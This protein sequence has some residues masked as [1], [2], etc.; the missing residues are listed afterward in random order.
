MSTKIKSNS[1]IC[2]QCQHSFVWVKS[3]NKLCWWCEK[4]LLPEEL[5]QT[6][7]SL[8]TTSKVTAIRWL[9]EG[10]RFRIVGTDKEGVLI[11]TNECR[12]LTHIAGN[13]E[14]VA[15]GTEVV[16][17]P[18][19]VKIDQ[20]HNSIAKDEKKLLTK[21]AVVNPTGKCLCGCGEPTSGSKFKPGHDARFHGRIR[22]I[23]NGKLTIEQL[24]EEIGRKNYAMPS[25]EAALTDHGR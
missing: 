23:Q 11:K 18:G 19:T 21:S 25:Y 7:V 10:Q 6:P 13:E 17:L 4:K 5:I 2:Q 9:S 3:K 15:P 8:P 24:Q 16:V 1:D 22:R 20:E 12:A 14:S